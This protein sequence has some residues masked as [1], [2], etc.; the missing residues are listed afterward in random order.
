MSSYIAMFQP[1]HP[2]LVQ[3][4]GRAKGDLF[5]LRRDYGDYRAKQVLRFPAKLL[6]ARIFSDPVSS[7][8]G[9]RL[10]S[11]P[12]TVQRTL[13]KTSSVTA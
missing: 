12:F 8:T 6:K 2:L 10:N 13:Q 1:P 9:V 7:A 4:P 11:F 5:G 3:Y